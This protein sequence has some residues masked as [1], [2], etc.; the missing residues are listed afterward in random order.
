[1]SEFRVSIEQD[2]C[3][4]CSACPDYAPKYFYMRQN[5][6]AYVKDNIDQDPEQISHQGFGDS[7]DIEEADLNVVS[8]AAEF[9]PGQCIYLEPVVKVDLVT[10]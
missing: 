9:C 10:K 1:M 6:M 4:G 3:T 5:G 7:V 8:D 2:E